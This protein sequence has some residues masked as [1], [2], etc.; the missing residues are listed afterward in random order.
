MNRLAADPVWLA[1]LRADCERP[2]LR[3]RVPLLARMHGQEHWIGSVEPDLLQRIGLEAL[4][5]KHG[6]L[7]QADAGAAEPA[8]VLVGEL[9]PILA[10][11]AQALRAAGMAGAWRGEALAVSSDTGQKL[12]TIERAAVRPLGIGTH[13]VHLVGLVGPPGPQQRVWVQQ[14][15]FTKP[16]DPGLWDTL[17]GGMVSAEDTLASALERETWEEAGLRLEQ[18]AGLQLGGRVSRNRPT[19]EAA[20]AMGGAGYMVEQVHWYGCVLP[21]GLLPVN[22]DGEVEAFALL[23]Q[24]E[25][26]PMLEGGVFTPEAALILVEVLRL[27]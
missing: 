7:L 16:N 3:P 15:S 25:L 2:P 9:Q 21:D 14:R 5:L 27:G 20:Y 23:E 1:G 26:L 6:T 22:R 8:C 13:A 24:T 10:A 19:R 11:L 18:L 12:A 17:M 4:W